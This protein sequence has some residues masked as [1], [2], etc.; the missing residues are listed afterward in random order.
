MRVFLSYR[1]SD[2]G[3]H[4]DRIEQ[5]LRARL[6]AVEIFRDVASIDSGDPWLD[7]IKEAVA[8]CDMML[9]IIGPT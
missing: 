4:V 5:T 6:A 9:V 7:E 3:K 2:S 1:R 8:G